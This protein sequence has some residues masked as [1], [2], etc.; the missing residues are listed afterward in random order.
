[1]PLRTFD[2]INRGIRHRFWRLP[3]LIVDQ[4]VTR[5]EVLLM[6]A[7]SSPRLRVVMADDHQIFLDGL[8][9]LIQSDGRLEVVGTCNDGDALIELVAHTH[10]DVAIIDISMPGPGPA[11]I[12][13]AIDHLPGNT[14]KVALTMHLEPAFARELLA[15]GMDGYVV[16]EAAFEELIDALLAVHSGE[17]FLCRALLD[18]GGKE[19]PLTD[20]ERECLSG[21]ARGLTAKMIA[22]ELNITERTVRFHSANAC[23]KF[24]VQRVTEAVAAARK[25]QIISN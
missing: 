9:R 5:S 12:V 8:S 7:N 21:S 18:T 17:T 1:M 4:V 15:A 24:G 10:P 13:D 3:G 2:A 11:R 16:K 22:R 23:R 25:L 14:R 20:R 6:Q 19:T